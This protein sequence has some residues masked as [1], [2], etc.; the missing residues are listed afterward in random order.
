MLETRIKETGDVVS[1]TTIRGET[2]TELFEN[3]YTYF[4]SN[5]YCWQVKRVF[6][7]KELEARYGNWIKYHSEKMWW[8]HA[9]GRDFD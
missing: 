4:K 8:K 5:Q 9:T 3:I 6:E 1:Y 7:D 2:E